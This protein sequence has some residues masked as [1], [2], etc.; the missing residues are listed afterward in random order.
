MTL[1][2]ELSPKQREWLTSTGSLTQQ[3]RTLTNGEINHQLFLARWDNAL[4]D[5][6][7]A[8]NISPNSDV[9]LRE[10]G[11]YYHGTLW[12]FARVVIPRSS[13]QNEAAQLTK[14]GN[15]SLGDVLF[16]DPTLKQQILPLFTLNNTHPYATRCKIA[17]RSIFTFHDQPLLVTEMFLTPFFDFVENHT[18]A[19]PR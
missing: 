13:I 17:K 15:Q 18:D 4:E 10:I 2:T 7:L 3:L 11:W 9:W 14:I 16:Q 8:L 19:I 1:Q 5:E 6:A 12:V